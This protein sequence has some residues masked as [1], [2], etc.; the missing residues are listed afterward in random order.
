MESSS[1]TSQRS[2]LHVT[3]F[4]EEKLR[5]ED[6][7]LEGDGK[8]PAEVRKTV[9]A[10]ERSDVLVQARECPG[11]GFSQNIYIYIYIIYKLYTC[12]YI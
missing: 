11:N 10:G 7:A 1:I 2:S 6:Q 3:D 4:A 9:I 5:E 12:T 8:K